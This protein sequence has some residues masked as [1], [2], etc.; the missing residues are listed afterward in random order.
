MGGDRREK[1]VHTLRVVVDAYNTHVLHS[2]I[3]I[4]LRATLETAV[5][6]EEFLKSER[7]NHCPSPSKV[8]YTI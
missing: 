8:W 6:P 2:N 3:N 7:P 4:G 1:G 5:M